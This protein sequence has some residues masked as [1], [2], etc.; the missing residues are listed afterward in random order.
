MEQ[1]R[2]DGSKQWQDGYPNEATVQEDLKKG[3][4][5]VFVIGDKIAAYAAIIFDEDPAYSD[6]KGQWLT[7]GDYVNIHRV[8]TSKAFKRQGVALRL[9]Q[10]IELLCL[11][12]GVYSIKIDTNFDNIPMLKIMDRL[13]YTYCG[14]VMVGGAPR[15][16]FEKVL[17]DSTP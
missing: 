4:A 3:Y 15:K 9:F 11:N 8:A 1:R 2:L 16:A 13:N 7:D 12:Q 14:E 5:Y 10:E 6:I 17:T